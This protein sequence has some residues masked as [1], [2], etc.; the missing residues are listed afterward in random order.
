MQEEGKKQKR[1][2]H[3]KLH[4]CENSLFTHTKNISLRF[5]NISMLSGVYEVCNRSL[6]QP[7]K[8]FS[9]H[10]SKNVG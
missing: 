8:V 6:G 4:N 9:K 1:D 3:F 7:K 10:G 2:N 5:S